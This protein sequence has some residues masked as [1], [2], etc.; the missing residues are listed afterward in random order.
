VT[1]VD[2]EHEDMLGEQG[3]RA[4]GRVIGADAVGKGVA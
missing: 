2:V 1:E 4:L 3:A